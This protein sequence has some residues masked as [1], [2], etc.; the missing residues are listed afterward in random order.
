MI[1]GNLLIGWPRKD[2]MPSITLLVRQILVLQEKLIARILKRLSHFLP[3]IT[4]GIFMVLRIYAST[5]SVFSL[6]F[7]GQT[8]GQATNFAHP[9]A[10]SIGIVPRYKY[11]RM[12]FPLA[13]PFRQ[14]ITVYI[15]TP[16]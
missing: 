16:V 15:A 1:N 11:H 8:K 2:K 6:G 14:K 12:L 4:T 10:I 7:G 3:I 13:V 5:C 9:L